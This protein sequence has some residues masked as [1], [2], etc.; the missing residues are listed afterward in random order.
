MSSSQWE[1]AHG[2]PVCGVVAAGTT[3]TGGAG[4]GSVGG[5]ECVA[6]LDGTVTFSVTMFVV[7]VDVDVVQLGVPSFVK[8]ATFVIF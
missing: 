2:S 8:T 7:Q 1:P 6:A 3:G 4:G 5:A